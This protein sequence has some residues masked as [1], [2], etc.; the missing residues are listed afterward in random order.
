MHP[1]F[2][3]LKNRI[4]ETID[5]SHAAEVLAWDQQTYMPV[6][7]SA[8]RAEQIATIS[9]IRHNLF[10]ATEVG[11]WL[12]ELEQAGFEPDSDE[13]A[14]LRLTRH[15]YDLACKVPSSWVSAY[16][17]AVMLGQ[18]AWVA[19]R[20]NNDYPAFQPHLADI[21]RLRQ[22]QA[23][24]LGY[25]EHIYDALLSQFE[26]ATTAADVQ[27]MFAGIKTELIDLVRAIKEAQPLNDGNLLALKYPV[28]NQRTVNRWLAERVGYDFGRGRIDEVA[29]P[30]CTTFGLGD[31]RITTRYQ[32]EWL[33]SALYGT[34]HETGHALY[35][36]GSNPAY[37]RTILAGGTSLGVHESQSRLWEN[38]VGRSQAFTHWF[39]P[40]LQSHFWNELKSANAEQFYR[41][42]NQVK[43]SFI[44]VEADEVTYNLHILIR[45]ELELAMLT[46]QI[47]L[48]DLPSAWNDKYT[49]YLGITPRN[50][51]E[52][53]LQDVHW[54]C[55][56]IGYFPTYSIGNLLSAQFFNQAK[57]AI[58]DLESQLSTGN[59]QTLL[60]WLQNNIYQYGSKYTPRELI[61]RVTGGKMDGRPYM[62]YLQA[63]YRQL[64]QL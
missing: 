6:K 62:D 14:T 33:P 29:H 38:L 13:A 57:Q 47:S 45:F 44:R 2:E 50:N 5:L 32:E 1:S 3:K 24:Y 53:V 18:N 43:P 58:P 36:Q 39:F 15:E 48:N 61:K 63:K 26:R 28:A 54:S 21:L 16:S 19:A 35:E 64:Y 25:Q 31:V 60:G 52:G 34:L 51:A 55:G 42:V 40:I 12:A 23:E 56:Y 10:T 8:E 17:K 30:F 41:A 22:E 49:E 11:D 46:D 9:R 27:S 59:F 20:A 7:G 37:S 4:A